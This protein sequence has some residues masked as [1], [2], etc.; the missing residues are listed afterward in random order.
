MKK[1]TPEIDESE[2]RTHH[3]YV[4][5]GYFTANQWLKKG[6]I[7]KASQRSKGREFCYAGA[8]DAWATFYTEAQTEPEPS[9]LKDLKPAT[10][11]A[12]KISGGEARAFSFW[13]KNGYIPTNAAGL[14]TAYDFRE[15]CKIPAAF[16]KLQRQIVAWEDYPAWARRHKDDPDLRISEDQLAPGSFDYVVIDTETTGL[17]L[18]EDPDEPLDE[19]LSFSA[20][21]VRSG[22]CEAV[23]LADF[24]IKPLKRETWEQAMRINKISPDHVKYRPHLED[25]KFFIKKVLHAGKK[26]IGYNLGFDLGMLRIRD[27][28]KDS[29]ELGEVPKTDVMYRFAEVYGDWN[30]DHESYTWQR[31]TTAFSYYAKCDYNAHDALQDCFATAYVYENMKDEK[32]RD[33]KMIALLK[34]AACYKF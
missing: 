24:Y 22:S 13:Y 2:V 10:R 32:E 4:P 16:L 19:P 8:F 33:P 34:E 28:G 20:V 23:A 15:V 21:G 18:Y 25:C 31:L 9:D 14:K 12:F 27:Y 5:D 3:R 17:N 1:A 26:L 30:E 6:R 11:T 29:Y 7:V